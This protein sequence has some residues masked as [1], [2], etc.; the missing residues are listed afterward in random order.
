MGRGNTLTQNHCCCCRRR[1]R[2]T[3]RPPLRRCRRRCSSRS[4]QW[5]SFLP[6]DSAAHPITA[7]DQNVNLTT[8]VSFQIARRDTALVTVCSES[9]RR[10][11][12][13]LI[14]PVQ[15]T[16]NHL[17]LSRLCSPVL[18]SRHAR[19]PPYSPSLILSHRHTHSLPHPLPRSSSC[20]FFPRFPL[21]IQN[22]STYFSLL[23][24]LL[25]LTPL[26][27]G[28]QQSSR[29][30]GSAAAH[31][32]ARDCGLKKNSRDERRAKAG[33]RCCCCNSRALHRLLII[34]DV[35]SVLPTAEKGMDGEQ[36]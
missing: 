26:L 31:A 5:H 36:S 28:R 20:H 30:A 23:L 11:V 35:A 16:T 6:S 8:F 32:G 34:D 7:A 17:F 21:L 10:R 14:F 19:V 3:D 9:V 29:N 4:V 33:E 1:R 25:L 27:L 18:Y 2:L 12:K 15:H 24:L 13:S 22:S